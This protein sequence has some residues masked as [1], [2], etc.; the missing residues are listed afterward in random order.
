[1]RGRQITRLLVSKQTVRVV[2]VAKAERCSAA[3]VDARGGVEMFG[4]HSHRP[5][6]MLTMYVER[7]TVNLTRRGVRYAVLDWPQSIPQHTAVDR[8]TLPYG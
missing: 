2:W 8:S 7:S 5:S 6:T 1:M 4:K 3:E